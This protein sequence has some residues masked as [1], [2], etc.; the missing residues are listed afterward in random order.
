LLRNYFTSTIRRLIRNRAY[1]IINVMG[2]A[3]GMACTILIYLYVDFEYSWDHFRPNADRVYRVL[4]KG[5]TPYG[6]IPKPFEGL[7][8]VVGPALVSEY[9]EVEATCRFR[10][11]HRWAKYGDFALRSGFWY[12]DPNIL[13]FFGF[14]L[15]R[16]DAQSALQVPNGV[17]LNP[18]I[19]RTFFGDEDPMGK[20]IEGQDGDFVVT[21]VL[22][23]MPKN[24][25]LQFNFLTASVPPRIRRGGSWDDFSKGPRQRQTVTFIRLR[26][27][28]DAQSLEGKLPAFA[29]T[30][31]PDSDRE[32]QSYLLQAFLRMRMH[33]GEDFP[34]GV[35]GLASGMGSGS[36]A[37]VR[38]L[39]MIGGAVLIIACINFMN[40]AT[41]QATKRA[42]EVGVRKSV[43][44]G[45][46]QLSLQFFGESL[47]L[48]LVSLPVAW[49]IV[50]L[51]Q[52]TWNSF[53]GNTTDLDILTRPEVYFGIAGI[54]I[55][56]G[57]IS[58]TYPA[59]YLSGFR[60]SQILRGL[61]ASDNTGNIRKALVVLQFGISIVLVIGSVVAWNQLTFFAE[62][63]LGFDKE[64]IITLSFFDVEGRLRKQYNEI[65]SR[66]ANHPDVLGVTASAS[67]PGEGWTRDRRQYES[68]E[69]P[70]RTFVLSN[71]SID[72]DY[73]ETLGIDLVAGRN[74][75]VDIA[76]DR[77][78]A[79]ILNETAV[80]KLGIEDPIGKPFT[81]S[82]G[83]VTSG[84][85]RADTKTGFIIGVVKDFHARKLKDPITPAAYA[86]DPNRFRIISVKTRPGTLLSTM[87]HFKSVWSQYITNRPLH[88]YFLDDRLDLAYRNER[89]YQSILA[90][91][92]GLAIFIACLGLI[93]LA[94]YTAE[95][96]TKE[97]GIRKALGATVPSIIG[98]LSSEFVTTIAVANVIAWPFAWYL[99]SDWL[100]GFA[101][102]ID[103]SILPFIGAGVL[104]IAFAVA[105]V[106]SQAYRAA[107][108]DPIDA[109]RY[110]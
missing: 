30:I 86:L 10:I 67:R 29:S 9:P 27:G 80:R 109:L 95:R 97:I 102:R 103:L 31:L 87:A 107:Q 37:Y 28:A 20:T 15:A 70:G 16:G 57:L 43:G 92:F 106:G 49:T 53:I 105:T 82:K 88:H 21:G 7:S 84:Y 18:A 22:E 38:T 108:T 94:A 56:I 25:M 65:K 39:M 66:L 51:A 100:S 48:A 73:F 50:Q 69:D 36:L 12:T 74:F 104:S 35:D 23:P 46:G 64:D 60:P 89:R 81:W 42:K 17:I 101:Y 63:D 55:V 5:P 76:S 90:V 3:I 58:G 68:A 47:F 1:T 34:E 78:D 61:G 52:P 32:Q 13:D 11:G 85:G 99:M 72:E 79:Y 54:V 62:K 26:E 41:A 6:S 40:L 71:Y 4:R 33:K 110:E 8:G 2:L 83:Q 93:G 91:S 59:L 14:E 24:S 19:V 75:S 77:E 96:R 45:R 44:A 98:L